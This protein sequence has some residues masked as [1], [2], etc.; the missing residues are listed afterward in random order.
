MVLVEEITRILEDYTKICEGVKEL[1]NSLIMLR[2]LVK[3]YHK[4]AKQED[5]EKLK[6][7]LKDIKVRD[8]EL[9]IDVVLH[10]KIIRLLGIS[11]NNPVYMMSFKLE[12]KEGLL[13]ERDRLKKKCEELFSEAEYKR[14]QEENK[15]GYYNDENNMAVVREYS[16]SKVNYFEHRIKEEEIVVY[17]DK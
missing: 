11:S 13:K 7:W 15:T 9:Y 14:R 2:Y 8:V 16:T 17:C 5:L 6:V 1:V 10:D 4:G 3:T 12:I